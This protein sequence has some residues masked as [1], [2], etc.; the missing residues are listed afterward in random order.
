[1]NAEGEASIF[2]ING[3]ERSGRKVKNSD[4]ENLS[5]R[6]ANTMEINN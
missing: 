6:A 3:W 5:A 4:K 1:M 2:L